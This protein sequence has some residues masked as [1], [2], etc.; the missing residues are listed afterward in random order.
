MV[1]YTYRIREIEGTD[2]G[3]KHSVNSETVP[4]IAYDVL[5]S[6]GNISVTYW[7]N[8]GGPGNICPSL[9]ARNEVRYLNRDFCESNMKWWADK[10]GR[11]Y[12]PE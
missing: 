9:A 8:V 2:S 12:K 11:I 3:W 10:T 7:N 5:D 4:L 1:I 6:D